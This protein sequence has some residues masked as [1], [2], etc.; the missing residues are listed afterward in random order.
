MSSVTSPLSSLP[1]P[2]DSLLTPAASPEDDSLETWIQTVWDFCSLCRECTKLRAEELLIYYYYKRVVLAHTRTRTTLHTILH[3]K[4]FIIREPKKC[5]ILSELS[6]TKMAAP[7]AGISWVYSKQERTWRYVR[8]QSH[9]PLSFEPY[10]PTL[11][12]LL[13][14]TSYL[15][16]LHIYLHISIYSIPSTHAHIGICMIGLKYFKLCTSWHHLR[17]SRG[18]NQKL[19]TYI[20]SKLLQFTLLILLFQRKYCHFCYES[21]KK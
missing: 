8:A 11:Y 5:K 6:W 7:V 19:L 2:L 16:L 21:R 17:I 9:F 20:C 14:A 3:I 4:C 15:L 1:H 12:L 18:A 13:V 10:L